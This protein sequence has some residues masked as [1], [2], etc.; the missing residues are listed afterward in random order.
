MKVPLASAV[1]AAVVSAAF[2]AF[3]LAAG[4]LTAPY[5]PAAVKKYISFAVLSVFG[6]CKLAGKEEDSRAHDKNADRKLSAGEAV[7]LGAALSIDGLAA[8]FGAMASPVVVVSAS[9]FTFF[10]TAAA[11]YLGAKGGSGMKTGRLGNIA[12]GLALTILAAQKLIFG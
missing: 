6:L 7:V 12:A 3:G 1:S 8:G 11:L 5:I 2:L 4:N 10:F 9:L